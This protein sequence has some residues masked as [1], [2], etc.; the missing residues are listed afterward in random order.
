MTLL[1]L[2]SSPSINATLGQISDTQSPV[3]SCS[4]FTIS[5][6]KQASSASNK[7]YRTVAIEK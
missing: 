3:S 1:K 6:R 4:A 7:P 2:S 5:T